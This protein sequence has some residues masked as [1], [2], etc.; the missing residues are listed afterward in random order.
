M[1]RYYALKL[2]GKQPDSAQGYRRWQ[3]ILQGC[4]FPDV[5]TLGA[6]DK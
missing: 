6:I 4:R 1:A 3:P 2:P 5:V